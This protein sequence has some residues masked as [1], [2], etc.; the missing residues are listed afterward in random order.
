MAKLL[1]KSNLRIFVIE[2]PDPMD[3]LSQREE[4]GALEK[5]CKLIGHEVTTFR[6]LSKAEFKCICKFISQIDASKSEDPR[7]PPPI[8]IHISSHGNKSGLALGKDFVSWKQLFL[9]LQPLCKTLPHYDSSVFLVISACMAG[10]QQLT[11]E[12]ESGFLAKPGKLV[13]PHY[14]LINTNEELQWDDSLIS[15]AVFYH[16]FP[17]VQWRQKG[18]IQNILKKVHEIGAAKI[19]YYRWESK[20]TKY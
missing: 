14:L 20:K 11:K 3:Y 18:D 17:K 1:C 8:C 10:F 12:I 13:P 6:V 19:K 9:H 2:S 16:Q 4:R 7:N 5:I 15:W